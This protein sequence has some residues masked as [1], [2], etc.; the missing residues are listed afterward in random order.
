MEK[1]EDRNAET[2]KE[3][4]ADDV[5][6]RLLSLIIGEQMK[7]ANVGHHQS[8]TLSLSTME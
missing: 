6:E 3:S 1:E 4:L 8:V 2:K 7:E 5:C